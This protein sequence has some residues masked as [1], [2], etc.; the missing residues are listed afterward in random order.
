M[1]EALMDYHLDKANDVNRAFAMKEKLEKYGKV[2]ICEITDDDKYHIK[3]T[4]GFK[5]STK[6]VIDLHTEIIKNAS[7]YPIIDRC[8]TDDGLFEIVLKKLG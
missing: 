2:E 3:I 5:N 8:S 4:E 6:N 1:S 7:D